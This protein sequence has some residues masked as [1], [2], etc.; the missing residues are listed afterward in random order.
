MSTAAAGRSENWTSGGLLPSDSSPLSTFFRILANWLGLRR[1]AVMP[2][3]AVLGVREGTLAAVTYLLPI[4]PG[5]TASGWRSRLNRPMKVSV[6]RP[7]DRLSD[8][9]FRSR[10]RDEITALGFGS[11]GSDRSIH[12][13]RGHGTL[14]PK[15]DRVVNRTG[16][17]IFRGTAAGTALPA[18]RSPQG[19]PG[20]HLD[21][22]N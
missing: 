18:G 11:C 14:R 22:E 20:S 10:I 1:H 15:H 19:N 3:G 13:R 16:R 6:F 8:G 5:L 17:I 21:H 12:E 4:P 2:R 9:G 7:A